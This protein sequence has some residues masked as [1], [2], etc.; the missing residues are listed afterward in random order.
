MVNRPLFRVSSKG[1][2]ARSLVFKNKPPSSCIMFC[3]PRKIMLPHSCSSKSSCYHFSSRPPKR[4]LMLLYASNAIRQTIN[5]HHSNPLDSLPQLV[6]SLT[7]DL[8]F[9]LPL[10]QFLVREESCSFNLLHLQLPLEILIFFK[11]FGPIRPTSG[12]LL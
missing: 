2:W 4:H 7:R 12:R 9:L 10:P 3:I 8:S 11:V 5:H 6:P 1:I